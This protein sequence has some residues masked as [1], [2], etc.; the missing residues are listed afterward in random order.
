MKLLCWRIILSLF[1]LFI[2]V[3]YILPSMPTIENSAMQQ[4]LPDSKINLGLDLKGGIHLSLGVEIN[5]AVSNALIHTGQELKDTCIK[6]GI[7][8]LRVQL[9]PDEKLT[10]IL[11]H[12]KNKN[13]LQEILKNNYPQLLTSEP[14]TSDT[15]GYTFF[16]T[17]TP[18]YKETIEEMALDQ[19]IRT[20]RNRIDQFGVL[21]PDI[22]K[23]SNFR[24]Q[25]QLPGLTE[26]TRAIQLIGQTAQ[27]TFHIVRDDLQKDKPL[28]PGVRLFTQIIHQPDGTTREILIP[29]N[30]DPVMTGQDISNAHPNFDNNGNASVSITFNARGS[31]MFERIT[32]EHI[33]KRMA[34]VLDEKVYSAPVIQERISGGHASIS[35][36]FS[37]SEAQDLAIVLRAGSLPAPVTILEE[38]AVGP[39]LGEESIE[40]GIIAA[41]VG[42]LA[43]LIIMPLYYGISGL[44][45]DIMLFFTVIILLGGLAAFGATLTLPGIAGIV[46]TIGMSVDANVLIFERIREEL[47]KGLRPLK[48]VMAG[49]ERASISIMDSNITTIIAAAILY[50]FGTGP[51]RGFAVTLT[52]GI[53]ASMFTAVFV[54]QTVFTIWLRKDTKTT[55]SV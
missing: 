32:E 39:S 40:K 15:N 17:F 11:P 35:G 5:K 26:S 38:R 46:L 16:A 1:V 3:L 29:L 42:G 45:A 22:R 23:Q 20:I 53:I 44:L 14:L 49:F 24:I 34:I 47:R 31:A 54:S 4:F 6:N 33:K 13:K 30:K 27:L 2:S 10:F 48:A 25:I 55:L 51:I 50:Q 36:N 8:L 43:V 19:A 41:I 37:L 12:T 9:T 18:K 7:M 21:E 28:S 52:L